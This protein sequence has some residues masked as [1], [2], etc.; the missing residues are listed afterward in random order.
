MKTKLFLFF[1][2]L[3]MSFA[4][5]AQV[6]SVAITGEAAGGWP[7]SVGDPG[8]I[9]VHQMTSTDGEN[10]TLNGLV[11]TTFATD[12]GIKFRANN[13]W[14]INWG[15]ADFPSGTGT[16]GGANIQCTAGNYDVTFN[17]TTGVYTFTVGTPLPV[18]KLIGACTGLVDGLDMP[19]ITLTTF[20]ATNVTLLD[21][22]GQFSIDGA[23][24]GETT[25]PTGTLTGATDNIPVVAGV[26]SSITL[27]LAAGTYTFE[28][29]PLIPPVSIV[30]DG[31]GGWPPFAGA[32]PNQLTSADGTN[33]KIDKLA[34]TVGAGKFRQDNDWTVNWGNSAFPA[35]TGTQGG[36][37]IAITPAGTYDVTFN[38][39]TG[40][41]N[42]SFPGISVVGDGVGGWPPFPGA[43]PN[44]MTTTDGVTYTIT[45]LV[46]SVGSAK[47]RQNNDW[48]TNWGSV[49]FPIGTGTQG[50]DNIA[51]AT[52]GTYTVTLDRITGIYNFDDGLSTTGFN[53]SAFKVFP[54]PTNNAWNFVSTSAK[55]ITSIQIVDMLG[56]TVMTIAPAATSATVDA[57]SISNGLYFAKVTT[58]AG[59]ETVKL[60]KN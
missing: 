20:K 32:D 38:R 18:V 8:P 36:D 9:D 44:Q 43:D 27:D 51:I 1:T 6:T 5:N 48:A 24:F 11:L 40:E 34:C 16:Q 59:T 3:L 29:A 12:G 26:Y 57:T 21:G 23:I 42:F 28:T 41:Y 7:G 49:D 54:N 10:W 35:G 53:T 45:G 33:Y 37:N 30:G 25:F 60:M 39:L 56:K 55:N 15:A 19:A 17:S 4:V 50:G 22:A 13:D 31:V 47:F 2:V 58:T 14:A 52:A 46:C